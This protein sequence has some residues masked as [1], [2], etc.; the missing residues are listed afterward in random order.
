MHAD[1]VKSLSDAEKKALND[2]LAAYTPPQERARQRAA[3]AAPRR[4]VKN[5]TMNEALPLLAD[6]G[7]GRNFNRGKQAYEA[8]Q[9]LACHKFG[10]DGG[11][12]GPDLTAISSRFT[13]RDILES[14]IEPSKV[15][16]EQY[17]NTA[18]VKKN[19][20]TVVGRLLEETN[21]KLVLQ[22]DLL[23]PDKVEVKKADVQRRVASKLS[24]M[25]EGLVNVL[26]KD[27]LLDLIAYLESG[28]RR[29][30]PVFASK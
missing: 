9:C 2:V 22:P 6:A 18:V 4:V 25:P 17:Q 20:D 23:K 19:G 28:G 11:S 10:N 12:G 26:T 15:I 7:K 5:W 8:A 3:A 30:H 29:D 24:P 14:L 21:D 1:A 27:E 13:R 16:S